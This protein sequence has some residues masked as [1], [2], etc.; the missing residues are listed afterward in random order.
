ML[1]IYLV[2][3]VVNLCDESDKAKE[4]NEYYRKTLQEHIENVVLPELMRKKED[5]LLRSFVKEWKDYTIVV[6]CMRKLFNYL[7]TSLISF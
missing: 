2:R 7:V 1:S 4:L 3:I 5:T 6:H